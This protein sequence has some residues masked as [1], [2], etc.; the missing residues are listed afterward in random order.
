M[1]LASRDNHLLTRHCIIS[2][3]THILLA[4]F[5]LHSLTD[6]WVDELRYNLITDVFKFVFMILLSFVPDNNRLQV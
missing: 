5:P 4:S 2:A 1:D 6:P 3:K